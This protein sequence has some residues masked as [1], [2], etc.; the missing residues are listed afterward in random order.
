[1]FRQSKLECGGVVELVGRNL[2]R[3]ASMEVDGRALASAAR[4]GCLGGK[5]TRVNVFRTCLD[6][7][8]R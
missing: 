8:S 2:T 6:V 7:G 1:M 5:R 4:H 3:A